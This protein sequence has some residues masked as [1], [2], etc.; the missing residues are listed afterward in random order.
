MDAVAHITLRSLTE[1]FADG[2][3]AAGA[4]GWLELGETLRWTTHGRQPFRFE[5]SAAS[6]ARRRPEPH[7][8]FSEMRRRAA[9][10]QGAFQC[11]FPRGRRAREAH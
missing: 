1:T 8:D 4:W 7:P 2:G 9:S 5:T 3:D 6:L 10:A 11:V